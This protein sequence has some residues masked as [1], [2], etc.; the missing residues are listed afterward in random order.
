MKQTIQYGNDVRG[1]ILAVQL[2]FSDWN[3][4][5]MKMK[6]YEEML[7]VKSDLTEAFAEAKKMR[8]EK[9]QKQTLSE[10]L[11]AQ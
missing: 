6:K 9:I 10:F 2:S 8:E 4:F 11:K 1:N 7:K 5:L 3:K